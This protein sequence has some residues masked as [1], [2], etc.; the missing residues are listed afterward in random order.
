M[1]I[2]MRRG[3]DPAMK[4][5]CSYNIYIYIYEFLSI[6]GSI[7]RKSWNLNAGPVLCS[8]LVSLS[9]KPMLLI[10]SACWCCGCKPLPAFP[11]GSF[12]LCWWSGTWG[13][14]QGWRRKRGLLSCLLPVFCQIT[15]A[16]LLHPSS[17]SSFQKQQ[18]IP[19]YQFST[20][21]RTRLSYVCRDMA[22]VS[23]D[24]QPLPHRSASQLPGDPVPKFLRFL[25]HLY[26][27]PSS[28]VWTPIC[29][30]HSPSFWVQ[31]ILTLSFSS[32]VLGVVAACR[33]YHFRE[34]G[35]LFLPL[36]FPGT[37]LA[38]LCYM[39]SVRITGV[40][41]VFFLDPDWYSFLKQ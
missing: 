35:F 19:V 27:C 1:E 10:H 8:K 40:I 3:W 25:R 36:W 32:S 33:G 13:R 18:L 15:L 28:E 16:G 20:P 4:Y 12:R 9:F 22:S 29:G 2:S 14:L 34:T 17:S 26:R 31:I 7:F 39:F 37:W 11:A 21:W 23:R 6:K 5:M 30:T 38:I 24:F 41:S